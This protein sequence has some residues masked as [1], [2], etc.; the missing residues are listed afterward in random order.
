MESSDSSAVSA[1]L[2]SMDWTFDIFA[3]SD[4]R[5]VFEHSSTDNI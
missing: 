2:V 4:S 1:I 5:V 3:G